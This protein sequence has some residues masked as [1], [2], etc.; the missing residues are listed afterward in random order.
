MRKAEVTRNT[1]E[2]QI[3]LLLELDGTGI[4]EGSC[5]VGFLDHML[6]LFA[7]HGRFDLRIRATGDTQVDD[8]HL[9]E[10]LGIA[11]GRAFAQALGDM[12]GIVRYG[13]FLLPMD[14][15]LVLVG[16]DISGRA[17]LG[18]DVDL[19]LAKVGSFDTELAE[20]FFWGFV[21]NL[22]MTLHFKQ[23]S[24][25]NTHHL[26]E[27]M[28]KGFGRALAQAVAIDQRFAD[29]IPSTKQTIC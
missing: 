2:T 6:E 19:P 4:Y 8:H 27:A 22:G 13:S 9:T 7:H 26:L 5:G 21:R 12:R 18:Y 11:L 15:S 16:L 29:Q 20:E 10:D 14:E 1:R 3:A 28:F 24:G 17:H 25:R 23:L